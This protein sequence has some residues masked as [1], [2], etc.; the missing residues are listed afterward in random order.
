M[1]SGK[2]HI[3]LALAGRS[4]SHALHQGVAVRAGPAPGWKEAIMQPL[5]LIKRGM[6]KPIPPLMI[7]W[8][9]LGWAE[10]GRLAG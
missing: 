2:P 3:A 8:V 4:A 9:G 5:W 7:A 1:R 10:Q 6:D